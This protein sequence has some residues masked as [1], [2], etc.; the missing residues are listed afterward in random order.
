ML[1][2]ISPTLLDALDWYRNCPSSWKQ[3]AFEGIVSRLQRKPYET[4]KAAEK[5][6]LFEDAV[7]KM[8]ETGDIE[9][10]APF[11]RQQ[12]FYD[13]AAELCG[14]K[15]QEWK[16]A[17]MNIKDYGVVRMVGRL[18][19]YC[20]DCIV[21]LKTTSSYKGENKYKKNWQHKFYCYWT[22]IPHFKYI[23][24]EWENEDSLSIANVYHIDITQN[25]DDAKE[26]IYNGL[27][28]FFAFLKTHNLWDD[29]V[30]TY[31]KNER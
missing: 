26:D 11:M 10:T 22:G 3:R 8:A 4:T 23:V 1:L 25:V 15:W 17:T 24:A 27:R 6:L 12:A 14:Y 9:I 7:Q 16:E 19:A 28:G 2:R 21:D 20:D 18:D 5:G 13:I 30:Y 31:S 29:Y